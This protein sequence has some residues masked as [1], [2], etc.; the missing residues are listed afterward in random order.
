VTKDERLIII[1]SGI[2]AGG[3]LGLC[4]LGCAFFAYYRKHSKRREYQ[5]LLSE[6]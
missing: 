6:K 1:I 4:A 5:T 2:A 3:C